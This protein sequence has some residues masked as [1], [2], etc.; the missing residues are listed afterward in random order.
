VWLDLGDGR[1][2]SELLQRTREEHRVAFTAGERCSIDRDL[3]SCLRLSFSF[4]APD[5]IE[6]GIGLLARALR[7]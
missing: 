5:E 4:Y 1:D 6:R 2:T 3:R 7:S